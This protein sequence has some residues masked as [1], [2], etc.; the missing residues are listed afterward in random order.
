MS[1][2]AKPL[3]Q[4][5]KL[6]VRGLW[7]TPKEQLAPQKGRTGLWLMMQSSYKALDNTGIVAQRNLRRPTHTPFPHRKDTQ[8]P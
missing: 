6:S 3:I 1:N 2:S 8:C 7:Q 5:S 4:K